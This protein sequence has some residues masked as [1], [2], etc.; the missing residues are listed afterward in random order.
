MTREERDDIL[1]QVRLD[2]AEAL[3]EC[4]YEIQQVADEYSDAA[5]AMGGAGEEMREKADELESWAN[6]IESVADDLPDKPDEGHEFE[7][8]DVE[9]G[10]EGT[11][12]TGLCTAEDCGKPKDDEVHKVDLDA[13]RQEVRDTALEPLGQ[14]PV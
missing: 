3:R 1:R 6:E 8:E 10:Q 5:E 13:W 4:A 14:C 11:T 2:V 12:V 9:E 7:T